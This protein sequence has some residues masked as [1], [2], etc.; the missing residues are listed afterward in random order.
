MNIISINC[1][2]FKDENKWILQT[3]D[4]KTYRVSGVYELILN[5][6]D[7]EKINNNLLADILFDCLSNGE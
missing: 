2:L 6:L 4:A 1:F 7:I 5:G 3:P